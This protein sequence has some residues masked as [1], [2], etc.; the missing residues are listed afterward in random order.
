MTDSKCAVLTLVKIEC[1]APETRLNPCLIYLSRLD[2]ICTESTDERMDVHD[3]ASS[4]CEFCAKSSVTPR[5]GVSK[6]INCRA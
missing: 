4:S 2:Q 3:S 1:S 6:A 5:D